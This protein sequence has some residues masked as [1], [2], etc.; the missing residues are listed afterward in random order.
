LGPNGSGK[1]TTLKILAGVSKPSS[2]EARVLGFPLSQKVKEAQKR[3]GYLSQRASLYQLLTAS[4]N[5]CF[6]CGLYGISN[7]EKI[8]ETQ[9][10]LFTKYG[11]TRYRNILAKNLSGG[12]RQ[13]LALACSLAHKPE[14]LLLDE[15]TA[16]IDPVARRE[17]WDHFYELSRGEGVTL[18][19]TTHYM[20]EAER[21]DRVALLGGGQIFLQGPPGEIVKE[22]SLLPVIAVDSDEPFRLL[23]V[24]ESRKEFFD[25]YEFGETVKVVGDG[26]HDVLK[27]VGEVAVDQGIKIRGIGKIIPNIED[28]FVQLA[29]SQN[30]KRRTDAK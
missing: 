12:Y 2:G 20:E 29:D 18:L 25:V 30:R 10:K 1:T 27:L 9:E 23:E 6:Y 16:G 7:K 11:L 5:F 17:L 28:V 14:V 15:P 22:K 24:L 3:L 21:C 4:Q 26:S 8:R 19:V 13:R